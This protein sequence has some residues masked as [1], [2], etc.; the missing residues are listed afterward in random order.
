MGMQI[1]VQVGEING[2]VGQPGQ[3]L[4]MR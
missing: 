3:N 4:S 2:D 1:P